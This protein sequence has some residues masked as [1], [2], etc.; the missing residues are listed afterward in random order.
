MSEEAKP[1]A[2]GEPLAPRYPE[3][4]EN[5]MTLRVWVPVENVGV[6]IGKGG[7]T[8]N[9]IRAATNTN[10]Q[11][12]QGAKNEG[13]SDPASLWSP[14]TVVGPPGGCQVACGMIL[15]RVD[16][17]DEIVAEFMIE[18]TKHSTVI[19]P[20]GGTIRK[21]SADTGVRIHVPKAVARDRSEPKLGDG[22]LDRLITLEGGPPSVFKCFQAV[23]EICQTK[24]AQLKAEE[25]NWRQAA[26]EAKAKAEEAARLARIAAEAAEKKAA[27]AAAARAE[28]VKADAAAVGADK[29]AHDETA[30]AASE[31]D[32]RQSAI[33]AALAAEAKRVADAR[34]AT[35][36]A[37]AKAIAEVDG[38]LA[39]TSSELGDFIAKSEASSAAVAEVVARK[40]ELA[41]RL[42]AETSE[43][44]N[45]R[46]R[47]QAEKDRKA[48]AASKANREALVSADRKVTETNKSKTLAQKKAEAA[49]ARA[50]KAK[51]A[52]DAAAKEVEKWNDQALRHA[53]RGA[54][55]RSASQATQNDTERREDRSV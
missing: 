38:A 41:K 16:E 55:S 26:K 50:A 5:R 4:R 47:L 3:C 32:A 1:S 35:D 21:L 14:V 7:A 24:T 33:A 27:E 52:E 17:I 19:G 25:A 51:K 39:K 43:A 30:R 53:E 18:R 49:E 48:A 12:Q 22:K 10:I 36:E 29:N 23:M 34:A 20:K 13:G 42:A 54:F 31:R 28:V 37:E 40:A 9:T 15:E 2:L 44:E 46:R 8:I 45:E 11:C 6:I